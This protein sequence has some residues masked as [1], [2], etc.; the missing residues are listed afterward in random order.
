MKKNIIIWIMLAL[1][2]A[3]FI[4][5]VY[6]SI[7]TIVGSPITCYAFSGC[8]AVAQSKYSIL[9]GIPLSLLGALFY[10]ATIVLITYYLQHR[11]KRGFQQMTYVA[12]FGGLFSLYLFA[13]QAF[14]IGAWCFYCVV[15]DTIGVINMALAVYLMRVEK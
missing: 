9:F 10:A 3:G 1:S 8:D 14:V 11:T 5:A 15:S 6:L 7:K 2:I 13:L 4:D 12:I